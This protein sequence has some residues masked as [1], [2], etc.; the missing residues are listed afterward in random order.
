MNTNTH[1]F[2]CVCSFFIVLHSFINQP[3]KL[4]NL[5]Y[6]IACLYFFVLKQQQ[7]LARAILE[8]KRLYRRYS[9][10]AYRQLVY[11]LFGFRASNFSYIHFVIKRSI[12][13]KKLR[14]WFKVFCFG[15]LILGCIFIGYN[16]DFFSG[17]EFKY[18]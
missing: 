11:T 4:E 17:N 15:S 14:G 12:M 13:I 8:L 5:G 9:Y 6:L 10:F 7:R 16:L 2:I 18:L 3:N 1:N